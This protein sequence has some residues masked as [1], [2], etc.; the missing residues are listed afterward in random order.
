[1]AVA[2]EGSSAALFPHS[3]RAFPGKLRARESTSH[4]NP[5]AHPNNAGEDVYD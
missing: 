2:E 4:H 3:P 5:A 1:M